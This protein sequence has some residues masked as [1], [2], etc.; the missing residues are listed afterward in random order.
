MSKPGG[1]GCLQVTQAG[2]HLKQEVDVTWATKVVGSWRC[3]SDWAVSLRTPLKQSPF[4][5]AGSGSAHT[6]YPV[7]VKP[8]LSMSP[9]GRRV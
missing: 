1:G 4:M 3:E 6:I 7:S 8:W 2:W 9:K 5:G